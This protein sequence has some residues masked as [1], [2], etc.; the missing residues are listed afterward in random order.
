M[1]R[2][3]PEGALIKASLAILALTPHHAWRNNSGATKIGQ[4]FVR[5]G[6]VGSGD[7]LIVAYPSGRLV[8]AEAK[9]GRNKAT[10]HQLAWIEQVRSAGGVA[11]VFRTVEE[12]L[13]LVAEAA[14]TNSQRANLR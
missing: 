9:A 2:C 6:A 5:F 13:A 1:S 8:S 10:A 11:G 3:T 14:G 7:I 12:L 4:R